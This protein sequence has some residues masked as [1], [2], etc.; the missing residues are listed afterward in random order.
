MI[1]TT[2]VTDYALSG[3][4]LRMIANRKLF[5]LTSRRA[6]IVT[7]T[8]MRGMGRMFQAYYEMSKMAS[9]MSLFH[10]RDSALK[11]LQEGT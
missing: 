9:P 10:D 2:R 7:N 1:D 11:W 5:S 6:L 4:E 3:V 8:F